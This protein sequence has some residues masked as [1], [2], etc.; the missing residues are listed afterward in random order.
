MLLLCPIASTVVQASFVD[1]LPGWMGEIR[2]KV[3]SSSAVKHGAE[4][5]IVD[6]TK[7]WKNVSEQITKLFLEM[8]SL[9]QSVSSVEEIIE[10]QGVKIAYEVNKTDLR[11]D[12]ALVIRVECKVRKH[13]KMMDQAT[14]DGGAGVNIMSEALRIHPDLK[15]K[16]APFRLKMADQT[17]TNS[18][19][20]VEEVSI[21]RAGVKFETSFLV[22]KVGKSYYIRLGRPWLRAAGVVH[23]W[24][25]DELTMKTGNKRVTV[26][27]STTRIPGASR[28]GEILMTETQELWEKLEAIN[29]VSM[30][31]LD[32]NWSLLI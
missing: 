32:L 6:P 11:D 21:R 5:F 10:K 28:L 12:E 25:T 14:L 8:S 2:T 20:L 16:P 22:L 26:S 15:L 3:T 31:T 27:T 17:V 19:G 1:D 7:L 18:L 24:E 9:A 29:I 4:A 23:D 13:W 30:E